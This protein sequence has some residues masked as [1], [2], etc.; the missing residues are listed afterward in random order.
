[1]AES[2][3]AGIMD[4]I[5]DV[6]SLLYSI[7]STDQNYIAEQ[8]PNGTYKKKQC[9]ISPI[10]LE[11]NIKNKG[12][13][14]IYQ[15]NSDRSIKWI[16]YDFD[17]LQENLNNS[18]ST[19]A[20]E[21]LDRT[22]RFFCHSL[23]EVEIPYLIEFS[24][25]R[26]FHIWITFKN[27]IGY[28]MGNNLLH[29][30]LEYVNL[31]FSKDLIGIDLFPKTKVPSSGVGSA[32][33]IPLSKHTKSNSYSFLLKNYNNI[34]N[35]NRVN[36]LDKDI[37]NTHIS[38]LKKHESIDI[39]DIEKKLGII[40]RY[41][42]D[43][44]LS[45]HRIK[46]ISI[47][48]GSFSI[49]ELFNHWRKNK[50]LQSLCDDIEGEAKLSN[51][52]RKLLVGI[53]GNI[54]SKNR[55]NFSILHQIF[56]K[57][58]NYNY[59]RTEKAINSL[60]SFNF[61]SQQKIEEIISIK[62]EKILT[63]EE[64]L[65]KCIPKFKSYLD[66]TLE[67]S[68]KDVEI[69]SI[70]E[71]NYLFQNDEVQ[72]RLIIN[73]LT[74]I[75]S[76][77]FLQK[78]SILL[79]NKKHYNYYKHIRSEDEKE[80]ELI[81]LG[82]TERILTSAIIKNFIYY[83]EYIPNKNSY[84][85]YINAGFSGGYIFKPWLY[86]WINFLS[87]ISSAISN[88]DNQEY[89]IIK[90]DIKSFYDTI[91]HDRIKRI[92]L[93]DGNSRI[94]SKISQLDERSLKLYKEHLHF[95]LDLSSTI[96]E[97]KVGL[98]QGPAY[99]RVLAELYL[100]NLDNKYDQYLQTNQI[101]FYQR[102][103]DDIFIIVKTKELANTIFDE[104][105]KDLESLGLSINSEKTIVS[106]IK[107]FNEEFDNYRSQS[108]YA[109]D[110]ISKNFTE[111]TDKQK[112]LALNEFMKLLESDTCDED[113][114]F[115]YSHLIGIKTFDDIRKDKALSIIESGKG[116]GSLYKNLFN[117]LLNDIENWT[118]FY[119][120]DKFN[121]LQ[122]EIITSS[123][124]DFLENS[125]GRNAQFG[126]FLQAIE[127][128]LERTE[129]V[130]EHLSLLYTKFT[131]NIKITEISPQ[132]IIKSIISIDSPENLNVTTKLLNHINT[133]I[134]DITNITYF[135]EVLFPLCAS[136][137]IIK[138]DL[139]N[140][141]LAYYAKFQNDYNNDNLS[142]NK[143][144]E[145]IS[146]SIAE[147]FYFLLCLFSISDS[148]KSTEL[149]KAMWKYCI[150]IFNNLNGFIIPSISLNWFDKISDIN[151]HIP[152]AMIIIAS[153]VDGTI[154]RGIEDKYKVFEKFS[155]AILIYITSDKLLYKIDEINKAL[156]QLKD[157]AEFYR[158]IIE[159]KNVNYF[160]DNKNWFETNIIENST[161]LLR[162]YKR[163]LIRKPTEYFIDSS[164]CK[165]EINGY[166]E[167]I[168]KYN[169]GKLQSINEYM[170]KIDIKSKIKLLV[171]YIDSLDEMNGYPNIFS[172]EK[173]LF[174]NTLDVFNKELSI[175]NNLIFLNSYGLIESF[176]NNLKNFVFCYFT[177][178]I[179]GSTNNDLQNIYE[180]YIQKLDKNIDL[181]DFLKEL[182]I[183]IDEFENLDNSFF[184]DLVVASS[185]FQSLKRS[186][187][188]SRINSFV[189]QYH[190]FN[191]EEKNRHIYCVDKGLN[192]H[193]NTPI[194]FFDTIENAFYILENK[195]TSSLSMY[196]KND[197][198][199]YKEIIRKIIRF[200]DSNNQSMNLGDF[201][202]VYPRVSQTKKTIIIDTSE[203]NFKDVQLI[204]SIQEECQVFESKH[205][206]FI[207]LADHI[208]SLEKGNKVFII[209]IHDSISRIFNSIKFRYDFFVVKE[210]I[211][212]YP[213]NILDNLKISDL[214]NINVAI[215]NISIHRDIDIGNAES[216]LGKWLQYIPSK[217]HQILVILIAAHEVM[218]KEDIT[219][220]IDKIE[221]CLNNKDTNPI[222]IK[223]Q[224]DFN[225]THRIIYN[226]GSKISRKIDSF[227]P[228]EIHDAAEQ[229]TIIVDNIIT[230]NQIVKALKYYMNDYGRDNCYYDYDEN[231]KVIVKSKLKNLKK[232]NICTVMYSNKSIEN[233]KIS[234]KE[235]FNED[236]LVDVI[237]GRNIGN[238]ELF[239]T[240]DKIG[241]KEKNIIKNVLLSEEE[242]Q[243]LLN[244]LDTNTLS[245]KF[246][247]DSNNSLDRINLIARYQSLP[248]GCFDFLYMGLK[249]DTD[250]H[251]F[252]RVLE[253]YEEHK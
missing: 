79:E 69:T 162:K 143:Q 193:D 163:I 12:S 138:S 90:T 219:K 236:V 197:I 214:V 97:S 87:N 3:E 19:I 100:D 177:T 241:Q 74:N 175:S 170:F 16:C 27:S 107:D 149:L 142:I 232:I 192:I 86:L 77:K 122:S 116:R 60:S 154:I 146:H 135:I 186:P 209:T 53:L 148:D 229:A 28:E 88:S 152:K 201:K 9:N 62:F 40:I 82:S 126:E 23:D 208:Y 235:L 91:S 101:L 83:L 139:N 155:N 112:D 94:D 30:I 151:I 212:S 108:K 136:S 85:Y 6:S 63:L 36:N 57:T 71:V 73:E 51:E 246:I 205:S 240:T 176:E 121:K 50:P 39:S 95:L 10:F 226:Y 231:E 35:M 78:I 46:S 203:Y 185:L 174:K 198:I 123:I 114:S 189:G 48:N 61:P 67:I 213:K 181:V 64:L 103:V 37:L 206:V 127:N 196:I 251:P 17:I 125:E 89:Y 167:I 145:I 157:K 215:E 173:L 22:V 106:Q 133:E 58:D 137:G 153:V 169:P 227:N 109:V 182:S 140:L 129:I 217:F 160:P 20:K 128:K 5:S 34:E 75:S 49:D 15:R 247:K 221:Y 183:N 220:F 14:A 141:A 25:N 159:N 165:N 199:I 52:K 249:L 223:R 43:N 188:L 184:L 76:F 41:Q 84:G 144:S 1:M 59:Q 21:E 54:E 42:E 191:K 245:Y 115:I 31:K 253:N 113:L 96:C 26:G 105:K 168:I 178:P 166:S 150:H 161:I 202:K 237:C 244:H 194:D 72:S 172:N 111:A 204:N 120:V 70:A 119:K 32:V 239:A 243:D 222:F 7:F 47:K 187:G 13:V 156:K 2:A 252:S 180:K 233:I 132:I 200:E 207:N 92:L 118:L 171:N 238:N 4:L 33:K 104:F 45:K 164:N 134:N 44:I 225:G 102:Y 195:V 81:T 230:G 11:N 8:Q 218:R 56:S 66:G 38:I 29:T 65:N 224:S 210:N 98:P 228:I 68:L 124:I 24:G 117:F 190:L 147:K 242:L 216:I 248:K 93:G 55:F 234:F 211:E 18:K 131:I 179:I 110:H 130:D 80:R 250:C 158:W 99:A